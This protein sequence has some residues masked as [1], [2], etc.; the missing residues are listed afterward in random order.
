MNYKY[1][2]TYKIILLKGSLAG[3]YYYGQHKTNRLNDSYT[4]S[5][6]IIKAYFKKYGAVVNDTYIKEILT[7]YNNAD[8]LNIA[9]EQ[10]VSNLW[11]TDKNCLNL[12]PGG[13]Q[14]KTDFCGDKNP[15]YGK[16]HSEYTKSILR[17][18]SLKHTPINID[19]LKQMSYNRSKAVDQYSKN[20]ELIRS[21]NHLCDASKELKIECISDVCNGK[22]ITAGGFVWRY[23]GE[24]FNK[25]RTEYLQPSKEDI[26]SRINIMRIV[27]SKP[28]CQFDLNGNFIKEYQST[29]EASR[30]TGIA[31]SSISAVCRGKRSTA[32][33]F[34]WNFSK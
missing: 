23:K 6:K 1:F 16:H 33:N 18:R 25:Y 21:W 12:K 20:G 14:P 31:N 15:F 8:E 28:V 9:E 22:R 30:I 34:K 27:T 11:K 10:L 7:F 17:Q 13:N 5:G 2:Y 26:T 32:G 24:P 19:D 3:K 4:G 29:R